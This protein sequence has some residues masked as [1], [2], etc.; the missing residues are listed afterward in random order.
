MSDAKSHYSA[1]SSDYV[2]RIVSSSP[3]DRE[4]YRRAKAREARWNANW[5]RQ[6]VNIND[7]IR[8]FTPNDTVG[9]RDGI[10]H[11]YEN[12][13]YK[14]VADKAAGYLRIYDKWLR[15]NV[16]LNGRVQTPARTHFKILKRE[17][18]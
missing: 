12:S 13:H 1:A 6:S 9:H 4:R 14:V 8:N 11:V 7:V 5:I 10:K 16:D 15:R 3:I 2:N 17:E 18:M